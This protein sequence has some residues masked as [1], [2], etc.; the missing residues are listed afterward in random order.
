[1]AAAGGYQAAAV[2]KEKIFYVVGAVNKPGGF[3][4]QNDRDKMTTLKAVS[5]AGG[6][7]GTAKTKEAVILRKNP[8]TDKRQEVPVNLNNVMHLKTE[9]AALQ[10]GDILFIPDSS[11]KRA[12]RR[13]GD[14]GLAL[15]T[16]I[17]VVSAGKL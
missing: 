13:A 6:M 12:L 1:M 17:A 4:M 10:A 11:G 7:I 2:A 16:G 15:T 8:G 14:I 3:V 9:D 5:L